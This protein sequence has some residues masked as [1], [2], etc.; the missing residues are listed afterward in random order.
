VISS[1]GYQRITEYDCNRRSIYHF[2][3]NPSIEF[4]IDTTT[5]E[6]VAA[7]YSDDS[8]IC[9]FSVDGPVLHGGEDGLEGCEKISE[10]E[11]RGPCGTGGSGGSAG[12]GG[13]GGDGGTGG[14]M[15]DVGAFEVQP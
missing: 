10:R 2:Q 13:T 11:C 14:T 8:Q 6:V 1:T 12:S 15:C 9:D 7:T 3:E 4:V 5:N